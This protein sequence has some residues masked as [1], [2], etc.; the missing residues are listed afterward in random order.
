MRP[1]ASKPRWA[2][3]Q[4]RVRVGVSSCLLGQGVRYNG[5]YKRDAFLVD[6]LGRYVEWVP[7]CPEVELG[8]GV[9]R[10]PMRLERRDG[11]V[12]MLGITSRT[13]HTPAMLS[14]ARRHLA[15]LAAEHLSGYVLKNDSPSCGLERVRVYGAGGVPSRSGRGL[16]AA[17]LLQRFPDLPVEEEGRLG[18]PRLR[19]SFIERVFAYH[20]L[21]VFFTGRW[22]LGGLVAFHTAHKLQLLAHSTT[23]YQVLGRLVSGARERARADLRASY[24]AQFMAALRHRATVGKHT[25][26]LQHMA[27]Y[28][29][30]ELEA[31]ARHELL[32]LID[33]Y[34]RGLVPLL[35]PVTLVRQHVDRCNVSYLKGQ[36]Y[37]DPYP[38]ELMLRNA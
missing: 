20:R 13:D 22:S 8:M 17:A 33:E 5:G 24:S 15:A 10:E 37:L 26:V 2:A 4:D 3:E 1:E 35:L 25:N 18:D 32:G 11:Q 30:H 7:V 38:R 9:P 16:F 31:P 28:F 6:T 21:Q 29:K 12:A 14:F 34:R 36:V 23:A 27:G 19:E